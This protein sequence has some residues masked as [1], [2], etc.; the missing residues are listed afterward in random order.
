MS[1]GSCWL[2]GFIIV[3]VIAGCMNQDL[4]SINPGSFGQP[5]AQV[6]LILSVMLIPLK[7][8][9]EDLTRRLDLLRRLR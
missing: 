1:I 2:F 8:I 5:M 3:I 7:K 9:N 4:S 6:R